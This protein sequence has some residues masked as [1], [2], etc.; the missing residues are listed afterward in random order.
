MLK[1]LEFNISVPTPYVFASLYLSASGADD[2]VI[3]RSI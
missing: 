1:T 2:Q 3:N